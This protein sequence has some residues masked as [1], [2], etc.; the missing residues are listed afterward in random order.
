MRGGKSGGVAEPPELCQEHHELGVDRRL[1]VSCVVCENFVRVNE[2]YDLV[3]TALVYTRL[4]AEALGVEFH[5]VFKRAGAL[6]DGVAGAEVARR[7]NVRVDEEH[8]EREAEEDVGVVLVVGVVTDGRPRHGG[9]G[10][11]LLYLT[12]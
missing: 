1:H 10:N 9:D 6:G 2:S 7:D 8:V 12:N 4:L 3:E 11:E 5:H